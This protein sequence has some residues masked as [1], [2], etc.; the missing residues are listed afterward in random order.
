M[1]ENVVMTEHLLYSKHFNKGSLSYQYFLS[2][3]VFFNHHHPCMKIRLEIFFNDFQNSCIRICNSELNKFV[4][5]FVLVD[6]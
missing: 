5:G 3:L 6:L 1:L 2:I 4:D